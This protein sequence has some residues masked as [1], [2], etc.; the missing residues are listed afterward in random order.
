VS[1]W[2]T[3]LILIVIIGGFIGWS[4]YVKPTPISLYVIGYVLLG[5]LFIDFILDV[6]PVFDSD[7]RS[8]IT[9]WASRTATGMALLA[10]A[11]T[12]RQLKPVYAR[13]PVMFAYVPVAILGV[14]PVIEES[15]VLIRIVYIMVFGSALLVLLLMAINQAM[16]KDRSALGFFIAIALVTSSYILEWFLTPFSGRHP[17]TVHIGMTLA[18]PSFIYVIHA[19][20]PQ[21]KKG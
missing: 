5:S 10:I 14:F 16:N 4:R 7:L 9:M 13:Y 6:L 21:F 18:I 11:H 17:W 1:I 2:S 12:M 20:Q 19:L 3:L 15:F 8:T